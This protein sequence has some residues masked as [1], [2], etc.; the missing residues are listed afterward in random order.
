MGYTAG[1]EVRGMI[2]IQRLDA[3]IAYIEAHPEEHEQAYWFHRTDE[4]CG[5]AACLAGT[6]ALLDG[7]EPV[8]WVPAGHGVGETTALVSKDGQICEV[9]DLAFDLLG[10]ERSTST[11]SWTETV[12]EDLVGEMFET[13]NTF[14]MIKKLRDRIAASQP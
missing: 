1:G 14:D 11:D 13:A 2:D 8:G 5:T 3:A 9:D 6:L 12:D 4:G 10:C 7:W